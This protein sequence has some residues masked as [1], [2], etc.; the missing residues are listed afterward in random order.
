VLVD[1]HCHLTDVGFGTGSRAAVDRAE[2]AGVAR[3]VVIGE[4]P[5][6]AGQALDMT[7]S[8][9][10]LAATAGIHPHIASRWTEET[11]TWLERMLREPRIVAAGEMG[12][13][14][15]YERTPRGTQR[16]AFEAQL[17][18]AAGAGKPAVV[19]A[20]EADDDVAAVLRNHPRTTVILHSFS[21]GPDL[22]RAGLDLGHYFS[23]S[24]M[25]TFK[26]WAAD[27]A[28]LRVP[29]DRLLV[30]TDAPYLAPVP[31]RGKRNEPAYVVEVARRLA[32]V[33]GLSY[34]EICRITTDNAARVFALDLEHA[35]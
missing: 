35:A 9:P 16:P 2:A 20:R 27:G 18:L 4:S 25:I 7:R 14:Y 15:H 33:R 11:A 1:T 31:K 32:T 30:E 34:E 3:V 26:N 8:D 13:D 23:F 19:H 5:E 10:R 21:S 29:L 17:E 24:G 6:A 22:L 12:L 28:I